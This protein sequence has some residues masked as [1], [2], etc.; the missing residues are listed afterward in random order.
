VW[1]GSSKTVVV[2]CPSL[3]H[4]HLFLLKMLKT[5][6]NFSTYQ[7]RPLFIF[8]FCVFT[9]F[10]HPCSSCYH[11]QKYSFRLHS[12]FSVMVLPCYILSYHCIF[13]CCLLFE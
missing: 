12:I 4:E 6:C 7:N 1:H 11:L 13:E 2:P 9:I 5:Q 8:F 10:I 3:G